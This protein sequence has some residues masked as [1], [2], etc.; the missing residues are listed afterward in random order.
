MYNKFAGNDDKKQTNYNFEAKQNSGTRNDKFASLSSSEILG[1]ELKEAIHHMVANIS[2]SF[3]IDWY[4]S[5]SPTNHDFVA[6]CEGLID[7]VL[8]KLAEICVKKL[9]KYKIGQLVISLLHDHILNENTDEKIQSIEHQIE[10]YEYDICQNSVV[11]LFG[12]LSNEKLRRVVFTTLNAT[13]LNDLTRRN[14]NFQQSGTSNGASHLRHVRSSSYSGPSQTTNFSEIESPAR[15]TS[16]LYTLVIAMLTKAAFMPIIDVISQPNWLYALIIWLCQKEERDKVKRNESLR[17]QD[18]NTSMKSKDDSQSTRRKLGVTDTG[19]KDIGNMNPTSSIIMTRTYRSIDLEEGINIA[20]PSINFDNPIC[21]SLKRPLDN[22][23]IYA[24]EEVKSSS[25][26]YILY[27]IRYDGL[28]YRHPSAGFNFISEQSDVPIIDKRQTHTTNR[29]LHG[30]EPR[31]GSYAIDYSHDM[32][33]RKSFRRSMTIKRR[34]REFVL[35]QLRLE[36]NPKIRPYMK[37]IPKPTKL[38]AATQNIFSLPGITNIKLDQSTIKLRQRFLERFL[39]A[40]NSSPFIA[41][42]YEFKEFF[43]YNVNSAG[44]NMSRSKSTILQVNLNKVFVDSVRSAFSIIRSTLPGEF[45]DLDCWVQDTRKSKI[46]L[47]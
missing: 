37:N 42:S 44:V 46:S 22:I 1:N 8:T 25:S 7:E 23:E 13:F 47:Y 43:S 24:T 9:D 32:S 31:T 27:C 11:R 33:G 35:L 19:A 2:K 10:N 5:I 41:N 26:C 34:F 36:E 30:D 3:I 40:L 16:A 15:T 14:N 21:D 18:E 17:Q 39:I 20:S 38:K 12:L 29:R 28:C 6:S 4:T 45:D